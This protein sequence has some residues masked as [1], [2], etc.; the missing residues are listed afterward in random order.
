MTGLPA[1]TPGWY[2]DQSGHLRWWDGAQWGPY[3]PPPIDSGGS[4]AVVSHLGMFVGGFVLP[5][6]IYLTEGKKNGFVRHHSREALNFQITLTLAYIV[7]FVLMIILIG[8][9][10]FFVVWVGSIALMIVAAVKV[11]NGEPY[12]YPVAL[13]LIN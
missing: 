11:N 12:R 6:V 8:I 9:L 4:L 1:P 2:P 10:V 13:R 7:S 3:A 5:L